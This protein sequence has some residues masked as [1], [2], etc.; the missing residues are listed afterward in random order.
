MAMRLLRLRRRA[1]LGNNNNDSAL[2]PIA[3]LLPDKIRVR[4]V[5]MTTT[6]D[7]GREQ[8]RVLTSGWWSSLSFWHLRRWETNLQER[9]SEVV[10]EKSV[11][12]ENDFQSPTFGYKAPI[13]SPSPC[14]SLEASPLYPRRNISPAFDETHEAT[15]FSFGTKKTPRASDKRFP[16]FLEKKG[17]YSFGRESSAEPDEDLVLSDPSSDEKDSDGSI[18]EDSP[19]L[20]EGLERAVALQNFEKKLKTFNY[21]HIITEAYVPIAKQE[22]QEIIR[23]IHE[24][25]KDDVGNH[26]EDFKISAIGGLESNQQTLCT[27]GDKS[28]E[29]RPQET[30]LDS[31]TKRINEASPCSGFHDFLEKKGDYSTFI[32]PSMA[33]SILHGARRFSSSSGHDYQIYKPLHDDEI[34]PTSILFKGCDYEHWIILVK[35][36]TPLSPDQMIYEYEKICGRGLGIS[37]GKARKK[38]YA[39]STDTY[40][41]FQATMKEE[42]SKKFNSLP[43]VLF[44]LPDSYIYEE[45]GGDRY[46]EGVITPSRRLRFKAAGDVWNPQWDAYF[47]GGGAKDIL[48]RKEI[49][50]RVS[51]GDDP[52]PLLEMKDILEDLLDVRKKSEVTS[53]DFARQLHGRAATMDLFSIKGTI[54]EEVVK[55]LQVASFTGEKQ[56]ISN[57]NKHLV[58]AYKAGV[59]D[60]GLRLGTL[61]LVVFCSYALAVWYG[62]KLILDKGYTGGQVLNIIISVLTGSM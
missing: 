21:S 10:K 34:T 13:S 32:H 15:I 31:A 28:G 42:E 22:P 61:F 56:A 20:V 48:T 60:T 57:Y 6:G 12:P 53:G 33:P 24:K 37:V 23:M 36:P 43:E 35:F 17:D 45:Y 9:P 62:G 1:R 2:S 50:D 14:L 38:I 55:K 7:I 51:P 18:E 44:V 40:T 59:M 30:K 19:A 8:N 5:A 41:G 39:C 58:T 49:I 47:S 52:S 26:V 25:L 46:E 54:C 4:A 11:E 27:V 29:T 3:L 16:E